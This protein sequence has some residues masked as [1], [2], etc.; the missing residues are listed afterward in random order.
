MARHEFRALRPLP[1]LVAG[2][3]LV[4]PVR[5]STAESVANVLSLGIEFVLLTLF[6][7]ATETV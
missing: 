5:R 6:L 7:A 2:T 3:T 1:F 4:I